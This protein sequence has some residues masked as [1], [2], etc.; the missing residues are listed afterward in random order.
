MLPADAAVA[1]LLPPLGADALM[2]VPLRVHEA[3]PHE[4]QAEV[5]RLLAVVPGEHAEAAGIDRERLVQREL[6]REVRNRA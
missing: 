6:R 1:L 3:D 4:W 5:A 2:E